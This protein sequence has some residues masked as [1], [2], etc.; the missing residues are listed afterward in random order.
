MRAENIPEP[1]PRKQIL[2]DLEILI[3]EKRAR[4]Y[5]PIL[6][7][8][9]NGDY[10]QGEDND[11]KNFLTNSALCDPYS[12]RFKDPIRTYYLHGPNRIDYIFMDMA[13]TTAI[14]SIGYLGTHDGAI[15]DH[16]LA[17]VDMNHSQI[18]AGLINRPPPA[19]LRDILIEQED[20][21]Q[22]FLRLIHPQLD[23]QNYA[24]RVFTLAQDFAQHSATQTNI[25]RYNNMYTQLLEMIQG[26]TKQVGKKPIGYMRSR[27]LTT[28]GNH[29]LLSRYLFD[30]KTRGTP[31]MKKLLQLGERLSVDVIALLELPEQDLRKLMRSNRN[32]L[33]ECQKNCAS[34]REEF[35]ELEARKRATA[36][37]DKD[38]QARVRQMKRKIKTTAM[39][40]KLTA[41]TK[42]PQ[43]ALKMIQVPTHDWFYSELSNE[44]FHYHKGVFEAFPAADINLFHSH[45]TRKVLPPEAQAVQVGRNDTGTHWIITNIIPNPT[46][47]WCEITNTE[48]IEAELL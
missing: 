47:L 15:S 25:D 4:G 39:N 45:H 7:I 36:A 2:T 30:C 35:L 5:R 48:E 29:V 46:N 18:F 28:A 11:L 41:I 34:L 9:A 31:P 43:G 44:L 20:K 12:D 32:H 24:E 22:A 13:L 23:A 40:R 14:T 16:V 3:R 26:V 10:L 27:T 37:G 6:L 1:N 19:H 21:V 33:W 17:Y 38:W 42:G 8:D